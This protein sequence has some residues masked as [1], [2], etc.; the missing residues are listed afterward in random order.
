M[1]LHPDQ[2]RQS[3]SKSINKTIMGNFK[4]N[5]K[6]N[7]TAILVTQLPNLLSLNINTDGNINVVFSTWIST[8][9]SPSLFFLFC[10][11]TLIIALIVDVLLTFL[12]DVS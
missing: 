2:T 7:T 4:Q 9:Y 8:I 10:I 3:K 12:Q 5:Y 11:L 1:D 6:K